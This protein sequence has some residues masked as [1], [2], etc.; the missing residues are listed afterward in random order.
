MKRTENQKKSKREEIH[1]YS[2]TLKMSTFL[3]QRSCTVLLH[4][5]KFV[6]GH[7]AEAA[8]VGRESIQL[9]SNVHW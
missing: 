9:T 7:T 2:L 5:L 6:E 3:V 8:P 4:K 1:I